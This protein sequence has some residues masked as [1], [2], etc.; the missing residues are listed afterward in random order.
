MPKLPPN[1]FINREISWLGFNARVLQEAVDTRNPLI[2][3]LR[4]LGIFSNNRDEFFRVRVASVKRQIELRRP[5]KRKIIENPHKI[6]N[7]IQKIV[8]R[9]QKEFHTIYNQLLQELE[10]EKIFLLNEK[11]ISEQ[12]GTFVREFFTD[13]V[14]PAL[15]PIMLENIDEFPTLRDAY[16]YFA[17]EMLPSNGKKARY[18]LIELP[19]DVLPRFLV[20]PSKGDEHYIMIL[21]DVVR[22][23]LMDLFGAFN[24]KH[25]AA[26][27]IKLTRDAELDLDDDLSKSLLEKM[28]KSLKQRKTGQPVRFVYDQQISPT[29]LA[30]LIK[31]LEL[32]S[33]DNLIPGGRYH[34]FKDFMSFPNVGGKHLEYEPFPSLRHPQLPTYTNMF[35]VI[36]QNDL[37]LHY[38]Y[39]TFNHLLDFL[40]EAAIDPKVTDIKIALYRVAK[41]SKVVNALINAARNGKNVTALVELQARFDEA[42]NI[43]LASHMQDEGV[44]VI[45]GVRD[46][47]V[48]S[49]IC[50]IQRKGERSEK[51]FAYVGTGNFNEN[52]ARIYTDLGLLTSDRRITVEIKKVFDML[53][54][55]FTAYSFRHILLSPISMRIRLT[56]MINQ[57]IKNAKLGKNSF[58]HLK[59]NSLVDPDLI[60]KLYE[61]S[62]AGVKIKL[63]VRG[64]MCLKSGVKPYSENIEA[65]SIVGRFLEHNRMYVFCNAGKPKYYISSADIMERNIDRRVE[66]TCPIYNKALQDQIDLIFDLQ[67]RDNIKS[68]IL[69]GK[70]SNMY[71]E[72]GNVKNNAH[73]QL[74]RYYS[75]KIAP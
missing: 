55:R 43:R 58:I 31:K 48:H 61:A 59:M 19:T 65:I 72:I 41:N 21:D 46:F 54:G 25:I 66:V 5:G 36:D 75:E 22:Y 62:R 29:L 8:I 4:F 10:K 71:K 23:C 60:E 51:L 30:Y 6:L 67:L 7:E 14:Y 57:E 73:E 33:D 13:K 3:R 69:D 74:Y 38:P 34:N 50:L 32:D 37:L 16:V 40:R 42:A 53:E 64:I 2:E 1:R 45:F 27:T 44:N 20:L 52:T 56:R 17:L 35:S 68:R 26:Y 49:K 9:Q 18:A 24:F 15:V 12:Q 28:N 70:I 63:I 39:Q 11:Q 47:K